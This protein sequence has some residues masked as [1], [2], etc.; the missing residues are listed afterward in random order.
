MIGIDTN[1]LLRYV[2]G[3]DELQEKKATKSILGNESV[4]VSHVVLA[5]TAWT[6]SGKKYRAS[7]K[8]IASVVQA[9]FEEETIL[10]QDE[11]TVWSALT[12]FRKLAVDDGIAI[13][14]PDCL[15]YHATVDAA[16]YYEERFNGFHTFD[17]AAQRLP[18]AVVPGNR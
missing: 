4:F 12:Q 15:I 1:V 9:L 11:Q 14:F 16:S 17:K 18:E 6:L 5:E 8:D 10:L 2:L 3:D 13:D 7:A